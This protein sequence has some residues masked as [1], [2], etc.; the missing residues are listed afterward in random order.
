MR[1]LFDHHGKAIELKQPI[2]RRSMTFL[3]N[4]WANMLSILAIGISLWVAI[5]S[6]LER[7]Q[8]RALSKLDLRPE[9]HLRASLDSSSPHLRIWNTGP[10][11]AIKLRVV[12]F[13]HWYVEKAGKFAAT[14]SESNMDFFFE[15]LESHQPKVLSLR[16]GFI[17]T[18]EIYRHQEATLSR[19]A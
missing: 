19:F 7:Q 3:G 15:K 17:R 10:L 6:H 8:T 5:N 2:I 4:N 13:R 11:E 12:L 9:I 18:Q 1:K 14:A 16:P